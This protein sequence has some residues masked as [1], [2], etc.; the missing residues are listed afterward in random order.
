MSIMYTFNIKCK[1][2]R[3]DAMNDKNVIQRV[4]EILWISYKFQHLGIN[5]DQ[6]THLAKESLL[7]KITEG[8]LEEYIQKRFLERKSDFKIGKRKI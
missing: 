5:V 1:N 6:L 3:G 2:Y 4:L 7:L 8:E